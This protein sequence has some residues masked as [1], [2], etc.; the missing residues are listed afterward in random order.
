METKAISN[1]FVGLQKFTLA[2][3]G[4]CAS[5]NMNGI[6]LGG[7][8]HQSQSSFQCTM[9]TCEVKIPPALVNSILTLLLMLV[10]HLTNSMLLKLAT[11]KLLLVHH[12]VKCPTHAGASG[13]TK[14]RPLTATAEF[15]KTI[16]S[17]E[18]QYFKVR[19]WSLNRI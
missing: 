7:Q 14:G 11:W 8:L 1:I 16:H 13:K 4:R 19:H 6:T 3:L 5:Q 10:V 2:L 9:W 15:G 17:F 18:S 12:Q